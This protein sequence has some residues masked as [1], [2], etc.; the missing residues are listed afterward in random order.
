[1]SQLC[2]CDKA[3]KTGGKFLATLIAD[4]YVDNGDGTV[5]DKTT[6]LQWMRCVLGEHWRDG[7]CSGSPG[8]YEWSGAMKAEMQLNAKGFAGYDDWRIPTIEELCSLIEKPAAKG[9]FGKLLGSLKSDDGGLKYNTEAF[10]LGH[11]D[12]LEYSYFISSTPSGPWRCAVNFLEGSEA[13]L[14]QG[15][16]L[17]EGCLR[18]VRG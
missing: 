3:D 10:P 1:M 5:T 9:L 6:E 8:Q 18:L 12:D 13:K 16:G 15:E 2:A 11:G 17:S 14:M 7:S 4:R